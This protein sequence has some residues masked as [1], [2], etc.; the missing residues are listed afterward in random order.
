MRVDLKKKFQ[1]VKDSLLEAFSFVIQKKPVKILYDSSRDYLAYQIEVETE[2]LPTSDIYAAVMQLDIIE[3]EVINMKDF[4][5]QLLYKL[6]P[7]KVFLTHILCNQ[8][9]RFADTFTTFE[10]RSSFLGAVKIVEVGELEEDVCIFIISDVLNADIP[11][12]KFAIKVRI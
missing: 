1:P 8:E 5:L 7:K 12:F 6:P 4:L 11:N 2:S 9:K 10:E 3:Q